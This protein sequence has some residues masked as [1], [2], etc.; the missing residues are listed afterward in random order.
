MTVGHLDADCFYVSA[1]RVRDPFLIGKPVGVLGNQGAC[2]IAKSY[3]M[4]A[5]GVK[6]GEPIWDS[7]K[8]CPEGIYLKRDFRWYEV[9][10]RRMLDIVGDFAPNVEYYSIDE[11]FFQVEGNNRKAPAQAAEAIRDRI[12]RE[13]RL[14]VTVG[15]ARTRTL[16]K[17]FSD[18]AKPFG[19]RAVLDVT[20]ERRLL[21]KMPVTEITGIASRNA[22]RLA[23]YGIK[24]CLDF[25]NA[26]RKLINRILTK[27]GEALW[28]EIN[29][30]PI[31]PM[32]LDRP[33]HKTM[34]RGGSLG[35]KV[36]DPQILYSWMV[37]NLE[38]LIEELEFHQVRTCK[39]TIWLGHQDAPSTAGQVPLDS[40]T[41]RFDLLLDAAKQC[42][43][44]AWRPG[45]MVTHM[46]VMA[47][48][49]RRGGCIQRS[50]F[51][52]SPE[53]PETIARAKREVNERIGRFALR[54][55]ATRHLPAIY[56][57][58]SNSFDLC[59][60]VGMFCF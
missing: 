28:Y 29:G 38:R 16:A 9:L 15:I 6:T 36:S 49:L 47:D 10:S 56:A 59:D 50:L 3:E 32:R 44:Q 46:H 41:D 7:V 13:L 45:W 4:K 37:R 25:A 14:P 42:L 34:A 11:F 39:L 8:K 40:Q 19:A 23:P 24:T 20:E 53:R 54:I 22:Q 5:L 17:L 1:E 18:T 51:E 57:V 55:G 21:E 27:T 35:V 52:P 12:N 33:L 60:G 43:R 2:V 26:D 31:Q 48:Q 58:P 30:C